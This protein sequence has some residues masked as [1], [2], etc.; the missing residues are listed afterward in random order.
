MKKNYIGFAG[1]SLLLALG[2]QQVQAQ[3]GFGTSKPHKT[4]AVDIQSSKRGLLIPRVSLEGTRNGTSPINTPAQSLLVYNEA[5]T[6]GENKVTPGYYYWDTDHWVRFAQQSEIT[7]IST[8][9][10]DV[11]GPTNA[12]VISAIQGKPIAAS[13]PTANQV[14]TFVPAKDGKDAH[15]APVSITENNVT[16]LKGITSSSITVGG[17]S[18]GVGS[19]LKDVTL[20]ITP[21]NAGQVLVT[22]AEGT[23]TTWVNQSVISPST[24]NVLTKQTVE[25]STNSNILVSTVNGIEATTEIIDN[26]SNTITNTTVLNTTVNGQTSQL[27]LGPVIQAGQ[28]NV[29]VVNGTNTTVTPQ[30]SGNNTSYAVN[31]SKEA[32]QAAQK[33]TIVAAGTGITV[34]PNTVEQVTTYTVSANPSAINL[35]GDVKGN[36]S[37]TVVRAIQGTPVNII[38]PTEGQVLVYN[39]TNNQWTPGTPNIGVTNITDKKNLSAADEDKATI[40]ITVGGTN[41]VLVETK[42][43]VKEGSITPNHLKNGGN[44]QVLTTDA[45]GKPAWADQSTLGNVI[46]ANNGLTKNNNN[47]KLGGVLTELTVITAAA[48]KTLAIKGLQPA[49]NTDYVV[50]ADNDGVLKQMKAAMPKFFYMPS[51]VMPTA[52]DQISSQLTPNVTYNNNNQEYS[53][54]LYENYKSQFGT[55]KVSSAGTRHSLPILSKNELIYNITWYDTTVFTNVSVS[56]EGILKYKVSNTA[57]VTMGTFMNIVFEVK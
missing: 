45:H 7:A 52:S 11:T 23:S 16:S 25:G 57:D 12:T 26:I 38:K 1:L 2:T 33:T 5:T 34:T 32:I 13:N 35:L 10:G 41:A 40:E 42:L 31:V 44:N 24:T 4:A 20:N 22:N 51:V 17:E 27:D 36:A 19:T 30:V 43:R 47:I 39:N 8:L 49:A 6:E 3:Q 46:T 56:S 48:D 55:P 37:A 15:W 53:V 14:L 28:K 9:S 50:M 18:N 21:G 29:T 54:N